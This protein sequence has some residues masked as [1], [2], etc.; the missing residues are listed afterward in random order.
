MYIRKY[1]E[2]DAEHWD[3]FV[4]TESRNGTLFHERKFLS[5]HAP[6]KFHDFSLIFES[7]KEGILGVLPAAL[8]D[9]GKLVSHPGS[10]AGGLIFT[11]KAGLRE[12]VTMVDLLLL[13]LKDHQIEAAEFRLAENIFAWPV[14]DELSYALWHRGFQ[15]S[16]REISTC[17]PFT[18]EYNWLDWGRK[19]NIFDIRK[20]GKEGYRVENIQDSGIAWSILNDNLDT[21]Y[22]KS[23]THTKSEL[24]KLKELFPEQIHPWVCYNPAGEAVATVICFVAN[25]HTVHDFYIAQN[26]QLVKLNLL[27]FVF[28]HILEYYRNQNFKWFN[29]GISSRADWIKWGILEFKERIGGRGINRDTWTHAGIQ[30]YQALEGHVI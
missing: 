17:I 20:A 3:T 2:T 8:I 4:K 18:P 28:Q 1:T 7:E 27:P 13:Y 26:Y 19:K 15:L 5:Y 25:T 22:Q 10:S 29:F 11:Q 9:S 16:G 14:C 6:G 12:L 24:Q 23:P 30:D 21:R